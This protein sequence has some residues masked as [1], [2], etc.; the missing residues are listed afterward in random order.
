MKGRVAIIGMGCSVA[1]TRPHASQE[2]LIVEAGLAAIEDAGISSSEINASWFGCT[3]VSANHALLN[4]SLKLGYTP[5]TKVSNAGATG[6]DALKNAYLAV[7]AGACDV[8]LAAGVEKPSDS[9]HSEF[10]EGDSMAGGSSAVGADAIVGEFRPPVHSALYLMR[11]MREYQVPQTKVRQALSRIVMR[12][13]RAGSRNDRAAFR[14]PVTDEDIERAP[15]SVAPMTVLDCCQAL[16]GAAAAVICSAAMAKRLGRKHIVLEGLGVASGGLEGRVL[17]QYDY[18]GIPETR[19]AARRAYEMAGITRPAEEI[20]HAQVFD[21]TAAAE[22]LAY[23][24]LGLAP[25]GKAVDLVI[26]GAFDREGRV[27][28]NT[29]GGLLCNGYQAGASGLRQL[30]EAYLQLTERAGERQLPNVRRSLVHTVGGG[31]G[32]FTACVQVL[33]RPD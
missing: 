25:D 11:Y 24:D 27:P 5:M 19:I 23:E 16:D 18:L 7:G 22:L 1:G 10:S 32:S 3:T 31:A 33:G 14:A 2:D 9:G 4:F 17:Q 15:L 12:S 30:Y 21:L 29:D 8:A 28:A 26:E 20:D 13:R 6:A